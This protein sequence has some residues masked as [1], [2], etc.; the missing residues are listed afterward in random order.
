[1]QRDILAHVDDAPQEQLDRLS[2]AIEAYMEFQLEG[3]KDGAAFLERHVELR[4]LLE[5]ML[6]EAGG[7][8]DPSCASSPA[9]GR[10]IAGYR[11]VREV[12]RG[13]M[14]IVY[15]AIE[16]ALDRRVALKVLS[17]DLA[18]T[19]R[20]IERFRKE[21]S[22]IAG[23]RHDA[24]LP[25][26]AVGDVDGAHY[27]AMEFIEG[28]GL[29]EA[30]AQTSDTLGVLPGEGRLREAAEIVARIAEA[31]HY[32]H[33][34]G[35]V[36]R[37]VKPQN[38]MVAEDGRVL[39][40]DFGLAHATVKSTAGFAGTPHYMSPEQA[41]GART[42]DGRSDQ[43]SLGVVL[44]ELLTGVRPFEG[45]TTPEILATIQRT[46]PDFALMRSRGLPRD[47]ENICRKALE[48]HPEDRFA[49]IGEMAA[50]L[51]R[52]LR[53][54]VVQAAAS[55]PW[56]RV[57]K[58]VRRHPRA[59]L[60]AVLL[61]VCVAALALSYLSIRERQEA[62]E[63]QDLARQRR[64]VLQLLEL[65]R[66]SDLGQRPGQTAEARSHLERTMAL[67]Q[68]MLARDSSA[69]SHELRVKFA[70]HAALAGGF[71][72]DLDDFERA[73]VHFAAAEAAYDVLVRDTGHDMW[74]VQR[75]VARKNIALTEGNPSALEEQISSLRQLAKECV[76]DLQSEVRAALA[77]SLAS[78]AFLH[79]QKTRK[80]RVAWSQIQEAHA[81]W[82]DV[83][84]DLRA[85]GRGAAFA[86]TQHTRAWIGNTIGKYDDVKDAVRVGL[87]HIGSLLE[88]QSNR[89][90]LRNLRASLRKEAARRLQR[91]GEVDE[92]IAAFREAIRDRA[93]I[94]RDYPE[95]LDDRVEVS[96]MEATLAG[97]LVKRRKFRDGFRV[98]ESARKRL[99]GLET[100]RARRLAATLDYSLARLMRRARRP[101]KDIAARVQAAREAFDRLLAE[102]AAD[103]DTLRHYGVLC[104][105]EGVHAYSKRE[106]ENA[107]V[108]LR[109][110]IGFHNRALA[111]SSANPVTLGQRRTQTNYLVRTL[112][113]RLRHAEIL[114][115]SQAMTDDLPGDAEARTLAA[116]FASVAIRVLRAE[117]AV[118]EDER[119]EIEKRYTARGI[120]WL[121]EA[122]ACGLAIDKVLASPGIDALRESEA[123][124]DFANEGRKA[125]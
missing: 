113:G 99:E 9:A 47:L 66:T 74:R 63:D 38:I 106:F 76:P 105:A 37:D 104:T 121:R 123:F 82:S 117:P 96:Q 125:R 17:A 100:K 101:D 89:R 57:R 39:L 118:A 42:I 108:Q 18:S 61:V 78:S 12:G 120:A 31:L 70:G 102:N 103:L 11:I 72:L 45:D 83:G 65:A 75:L 35:I 92:A 36:H 20:A 81:C 97:L 4:D 52:F 23:L 26:F 111:M 1:M 50:D 27:F 85:Y 53:H 15:E 91:M 7:H 34:R 8:E 124:R 59:V 112:A 69:A 90:A 55:T 41:R 10:H 62:R 94:V 3:G 48:K 19:P 58:F 29:D 32:V 98:Y 116:S 110:A 46:S 21:A 24:I 95:H 87:A 56:M 88:K 5:P 73:R 22:A 54:E 43:F 84:K 51:R 122:L 119:A 86:S 28:G 68:D 67:C 40:V 25:I 79:M 6:E 64:A 93:A 2:E 71:F 14:G 13:G 115:A 60:G 33:G 109:R 80:L 49:N 16:E 114:A 107:E 30:L 44:F 77:A